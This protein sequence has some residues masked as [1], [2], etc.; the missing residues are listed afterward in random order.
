MK[1]FRYLLFIITLI[2]IYSISVNAASIYDE[3]PLKSTMGLTDLESTNNQVL[4]LCKYQNPIVRSCLFDKSSPRDYD[5]YN[6]TFK[7]DECD[8]E[9]LQKSDV[10]HDKYENVYL[11]ID[12]NGVVRAGYDNK[13]YYVIIEGGAS[14]VLGDYQSI[15]NFKNLG[16]CPERITINPGYGTFFGNRHSGYIYFSEVTNMY[17][18]CKYENEEFLGFENNLRYANANYMKNYSVSSFSKQDMDNNKAIVSAY[19]NVRTNDK[20]CDLSDDK[21]YNNL[22]NTLLNYQ[23][24]VIDITEKMNILA[25]DNLTHVYL[26][27]TTKNLYYESAAKAIMENL[28]K[29]GYCQ[30]TSYFSN[31]VVK[32]RSVELYNLAYK[33]L[34]SGKQD[35]LITDIDD[36][37]GLIGNPEDGSS[38]AYYLQTTLDFLKILG[39]VLIISMSIY[40][41]IRAIPSGDKE[42]LTKVNKKTIIR[43]IA[44]VGIFLAPTIIKALF[45]LLGVYGNSDCGIG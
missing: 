14:K 11:G 13:N 30:S 19:N 32:N 16:Y 31:D 9:T 15:Y 7:V 2:F 10:W 43:V 17:G 23:F 3:V 34:N 18:Y 22:K 20:V 36:C 5:S 21:V 6:N 12:K 38:F 39:P 33:V 27:N 42:A 8:C 37:S 26:R 44:G 41:Y 28:G 4:V 40:D 25:K 35:I 29:G 24:Y 45:S 1:F